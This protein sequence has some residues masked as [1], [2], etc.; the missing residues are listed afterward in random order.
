MDNEVVMNPNKKELTA[1]ECIERLE[2]LFKYYVKD[3]EFNYQLNVSDSP[4]NTLKKLVMSQHC[5]E[6]V[7]KEIKNLLEDL[8]SGEEVETKYG[9]CYAY[10]PDIV[11]ELKQAIIELKTIKNAVEI[12]KK[13]NE[14][15]YV[16]IRLSYGIT[17]EKFLDDLD[18]EVLNNRLYVNLRG[19]Y[20]DLPLNDYGVWWALT[21]EELENE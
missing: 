12:C 16:Y 2:T 14:Q 4:F 7:E 15:K 6:V 18:Y 19:I 13:A 20:Y 1:V 9:V 21:K 5:N 10:S 11:E 3:S 17:K 8:D